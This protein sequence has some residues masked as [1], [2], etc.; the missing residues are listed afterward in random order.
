MFFFWKL[1]DF[2]LS[3]SVIIARHNIFHLSKTS[4][5]YLEI[6]LTKLRKNLIEDC[7]W[8]KYYTLGDFRPLV[9]Q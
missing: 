4:L 9:E 6:R 3:L 7:S 5:K 1:E 8:L 2:F